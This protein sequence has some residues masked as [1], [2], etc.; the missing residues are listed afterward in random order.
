MGQ[1]DKNFLMK[2]K[3]DKQIQTVSLP[4]CIEKDP[5]FWFLLF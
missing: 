2:I 1:Y 3:G 4:H 5:N